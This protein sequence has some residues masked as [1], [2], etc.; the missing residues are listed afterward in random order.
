MFEEKSSAFFLGRNFS[1]PI[2]LEAALKLKEISY[3]HAEGYAGGEL[4]HGPLAL[5]EDGTPVVV[6]ASDGISQQK[7]YGNAREVSARGAKLIV[8]AVEGDVLAESHGDVVIWVPKTHRLLQ[9]ILLN[10]VCQI[11]ALKIAED[12]DCNVDRPRNLTKSV[13]VE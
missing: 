13:T 7:L 9:P 6:I 5:I 4:K 8:I 12:R 3:I 2:A 10:V 11:L 1:Y